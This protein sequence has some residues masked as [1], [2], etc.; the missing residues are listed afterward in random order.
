MGKNKKSN[1]KYTSSVT[2]P[3]ILLS[4]KSGDFSLKSIDLMP[5]SGNENEYARNMQ[6]RSTEFIQRA[7]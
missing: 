6:A 2:V 1:R 3:K 7:C 4:E 5:A